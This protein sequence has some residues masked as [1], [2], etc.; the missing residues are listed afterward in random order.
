VYFDRNNP[1]R[2]IKMNKLLGI[3]FVFGSFVCSAQS[4]QEQIDLLNKRV[5]SL[6]R[7]NFEHELQLKKVN[8]EKAEYEKLTTA[9]IQRNQ[10]TI[11]LLEQKL[12]QLAYLSGL[13]AAEQTRLYHVIDSL[14][15]SI[16]LLKNKGVSSVQTTKLDS[17]SKSFNIHESA[18]ANFYV[19]VRIG[20]QQWMTQNLNVF[21]FSNGDTL[22]QALSKDEWEKGYLNKQAMWCYPNFDTNSTNKS[23][24]LY[25]WFAIN[26]PRSLAPNGWHIT[27]SE[28]W[29]ILKEFAGPTLGQTM[30]STS[31]WSDYEKQSLC[32][33][34]LAPNSLNTCT[35]CHGTGFVSSG[36]ISGNGTNQLGFNASPLPYFS[37]NQYQGVN[38][39]VGYWT[40]NETAESAIILKHFS[41]ELYEH[42]FPLKAQGFAVRCVKN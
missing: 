1:Q 33:H 26:D 15:S 16:A 20:T 37:E 8:Y 9:D 29:K 10:S 32:P 13:D 17:V 31:G 40:K 18:P 36:K 22:R 27:T 38:D 12:S 11:Q 4:K 21:T 30:K 23:S 28:D 42:R 5:D 6:K 39:R 41:A 3:V 2:L 7:S 24:K 14:N 35:L 25:N 19:S 34:E